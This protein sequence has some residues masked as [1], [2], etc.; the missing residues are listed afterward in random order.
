M[1]KSYTLKED[2]L[3]LQKELPNVGVGELLDDYLNFKNTTLIMFDLETLG[4]NPAFEYEQ[5]TEISAW[6]VSG[7]DMEVEKTLNYKIELNESANTL[8]NDSTSLERL[9]WVDRQNKRRNSM[10]SDP[11]EIL[12]MTHYHSIKDVDVVTESFA[13]SEFINL[14]GDYENVI[15]VA[16]NAKFDIKFMTVRSS[17]YEMKLPITKVLDTLKLSRYFFSPLVEKFST[18]PDVKQ[19]HDSLFRQRKDHGHVSSKLGELAN[20]INI[21]SDAWHSA[22]ADVGM[23]YGVLKFMLEFFGKYRDEDIK[24]YQKTILMRN[25]GKYNFK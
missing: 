7:N 17:K 5:I 11:N 22:D 16:H 4:L 3:P 12:K 20:A 14:I 19:I 21:N 6:V 18:A 2:I 1:S 9:N 25:I 10:F 24:K 23:M 13:I 8:L 15:L